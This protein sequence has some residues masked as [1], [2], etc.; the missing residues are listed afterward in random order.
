MGERGQTL[1]EV[2]VATAI[3][4]LVIAVVLSGAIV[5]AAHFGPDPAQTALQ[6]AIERELR[7]A[8]NIVKYQ[9][10]TLQPVT[11]QTTLPLPDG[12]PLPATLQLILAAAPS[13]GEQVT[14]A[15]SAVWQNAAH[16]A[17]LSAMRLA[18]APAP[19]SS[20][21]LPGYVPMPTGAP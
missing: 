1:I 16:N 6:Q 2:I 14:I 17:S 10:S 7:V 20:F 5:S 4:T 19:G 8:R 18:P 9:G 21:S 13:G 11:L 15:A 12:S 3:V